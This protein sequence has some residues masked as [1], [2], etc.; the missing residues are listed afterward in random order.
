MRYNVQFAGNS[1]NDLATGEIVRKFNDGREKVEGV[2]SRTSGPDTSSTIRV[3]NNGSNKVYVALSQKE[4]NE[5]V[6]AFGL[7]NEKN[8]LI[9]TAKI[10]FALDPFFINNELFIDIKHTGI[11]LDDNEKKD[12]FW[13]G[14]FKADPEFFVDVP[15]AKRPET[16]SMV[17]FIVTQEGAAS[18][19]LSEISKTYTENYDTYRTLIMAPRTTKMF[20]LSS[21]DRPKVYNDESSDRELDEI[22]LNYLDEP[23]LKTHTGEMIKPFFA[24]IM[25]MGIA[26][27]ERSILVKN[28]INAGIIAKKG[29]QLYYGSTSLGVSIKDAEYTLGR[30]DFKKTLSALIGEL[31]EKNLIS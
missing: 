11:T 25:K 6:P 19:Q 10:D 29:D 31:T 8:E 12:K 26:E 15:G 13:L 24:R 14:V 3:K 2:Y 22:I 23:N 18:N 7:I 20:L 27:L 9:E 17:R 1:H 4:L 28:A 16:L 5:L 30:T 21:V